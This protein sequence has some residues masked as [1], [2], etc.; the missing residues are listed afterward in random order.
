MN[1]DFIYRGETRDLDET[2]RAAAGGSFVRLAQGCTHFELGGAPGPALPTVVLIHGFSVPYYIWDPTFEA[3]TSKGRQ[4]LRYDLFGRGFSDRPRTA[5][6]IQL[7]VRQ[8]RDLLDA[9]NLGTVD[10]IGLS[11]GGAIAS[12]FGVEHPERVRRLAL[13][14]PVGTEAMP[15]NLLYKTALLPGVSELI[16]GLL[17]TEKMVQSLASD[18]YDPAQVETFRERY[19]TQMQ[20]RGFKRAIL[21]TLRNKTVNGFP[22]I[23]KRLGQL[24]MPVVLLWGRE[25]QT[26]PIAQS[27]PILELVPRAALHVIEGA[28]HIPNCEKPDVTHPILLDFLS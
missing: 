12:A 3:L 18:F 5:Y 8:L 1:W 2:A 10:L 20:F 26:L 23:Y 28:G 4:V 25:D 27:R 11:M 6:D 22:E 15:L 24:S 21:S 19:R 14:D 13:I 7:F 16:L 9:L 17:G